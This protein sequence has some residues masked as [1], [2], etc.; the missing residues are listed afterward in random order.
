MNGLRT[1]LQLLRESVSSCV[2]DDSILTEINLSSDMLTPELGLKNCNVFCRDRSSLTIPKD[3][4]DGVMIAVSNMYP[5]YELISSVDN[6]ECLF[7]A[8]QIFDQRGY[9]PGSI[10]PAPISN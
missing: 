4:D 2:H 6:I 1:N 5:S 8:A 9:L 10:H 7:V 3:S